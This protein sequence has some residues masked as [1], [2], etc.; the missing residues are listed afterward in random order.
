MVCM[1]SPC[2][3]SIHL[4]VRNN[5]N[6]KP[7]LNIYAYRTCRAARHTSVEG[8]NCFKDQSAS[9]LLMRPH[10]HITLNPWWYIRV[11]NNMHIRLNLIFSLTGPIG[12]TSVEGSSR[13]R[14]AGKCIII[15]GLSM[16]A[17]DPRND[18]DVLSTFSTKYEDRGTIEKAHLK[19]HLKIFPDQRC[20]AG[21]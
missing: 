5:T 7:K 8:K 15:W 4:R 19:I 9:L 21:G 6:M 10:F 18:V 14:Q 3:E 2:P 20:N 13:R 16:G 17:P 1:G 12:C 11:R